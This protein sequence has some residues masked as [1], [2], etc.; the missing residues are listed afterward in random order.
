MIRLNFVIYRQP[1]FSREKF[2]EY[3]RKTHGPLVA[4]VQQELNIRRYVQ[5]HTADD[6]MSQSFRVPRVG[7][8]EPPDGIASLWFDNREQLVAGFASDAGK[9]AGRMLLEDE[10]TFIDLSRS[11]IWLAQEIAQINPMNEGSIVA[12]PESSW[13]KLCYLLNPLPGMSEAD[14]QETWRMDHGYLI[15]RHSAPTCF[16]RYIQNHTLDD[17]L[18]RPLAEARGAPAPY[19][20]LTECWFD[21]YDL[22][23][24]MASPESEGAK[25]FGY[26]LEDEKRFI[27]FNRS[28]VWSAKERVFIDQID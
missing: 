13:V 12:T 23:T 7:M 21:R 20:G 19:T 22:E 26:F 10:K 9:K 15:R 17:P 1:Q 25:G 6:E 24:I 3:W 2:Q 18:N 5:N 14:C 27:D 16:Q 28:S 4:S 8:Q 11:P